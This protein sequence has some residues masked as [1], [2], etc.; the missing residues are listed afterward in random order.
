MGEPSKKYKEQIIN[1]IDTKEKKSFKKS[2]LN[3]DVEKIKLLYSSVGFNTSEV[4]VKV[5]KLD[6]GN[7]DMII[8][9]NRGEKTKIST[10]NFIG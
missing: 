6:D 8:D 1:V 7:L 5:K 10:I 3:K 9:I 2:S 4:Q